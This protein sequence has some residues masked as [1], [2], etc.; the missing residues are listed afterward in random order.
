MFHFINSSFKKGSEFLAALGYIML[1]VVL[2]VF[3]FIYGGNMLKNID[4][5][6]E[7]LTEEIIK[8]DLKE[9]ET[10]QKTMITISRM[11]LLKLVVKFV[12]LN[13]KEY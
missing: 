1:W 6:L 7:W 13:Q 12:K 11:D 10:K 3:Y 8:E 5:S 4:Y 9:K 2:A